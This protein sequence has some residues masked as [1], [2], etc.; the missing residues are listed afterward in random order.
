[1]ESI[2]VSIVC[3]AFNHEKYIEKTIQGFL[4]Q[5]CSYRYEILIHDDASTDHTAEIIK[6][7]EKQYPDKIRVVYQKENQHSK[8]KSATKVLLDMARGKYVALCEGDDYWND[9]SKLQM[10]VDFLEEHD[11]YS[12]CV[13]SGY[14]CYENGVIKKDLFRA[15]T[16]DKEVTT[17]ELIR[18]WLFPTASIVYRR[19]CRPDYDLGYG[20]NLPCGDFPLLIYLSTKGQ[21]YYFDRPMCVYRTMSQ[22][23]LSL[24]RLKN[25]KLNREMDQKFICLLKTIDKALN[26]KYHDDIEEHI[27]KR[28]FWSLITEKNWKALKKEEYK[29][30]YNQLSSIKKIQ[31][32]V[33]YKY[34]NVG[35]LLDNKLVALRDNLVY[36]RDKFYS[37]N[38]NI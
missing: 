26:L 35:G 1:M 25:K 23:S 2:Y 29:N 27:R 18:D 12:A 32:Y 21:I 33:V 37:R 5:R 36:L 15:F 16:K 30:M 20:K 38:I 22:S 11:S 14:Y 4:N 31:I 19:K 13:H 3:T 7:Y 10:Q 6:K 8:G 17:N 28:K 9:A 34:P 24:K